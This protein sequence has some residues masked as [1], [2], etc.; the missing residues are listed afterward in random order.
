VNA[1]WSDPPKKYG[2]FARGDT[3]A[4][5]GSAKLQCEEVPALIEVVVIRR[6]SDG[7]VCV[8]IADMLEVAGPAGHA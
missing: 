5:L 3:G 8:V 1:P 6:F 7:A 2:I 4:V